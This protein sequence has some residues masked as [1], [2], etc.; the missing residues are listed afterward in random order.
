MQGIPVRVGFLFHVGLQDIV[1]S[2]KLSHEGLNK[3]M[4]KKKRKD[5]NDGTRCGP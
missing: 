4:S 3:G 2:G 5:P 1:I